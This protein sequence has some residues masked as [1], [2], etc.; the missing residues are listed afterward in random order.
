MQSFNIMV[1]HISGKANRTA[2]Y[3]SR[4]HIPPDQEHLLPLAHELMQSAQHAE[5][6]PEWG[7]TYD[8]RYSLP[9]T[10]MLN[11]L[12]AREGCLA[13]RPRPRRRGRRE[14]D[15]DDDDEHEHVSGN[16]NPAIPM[17][18][19][20]LPGE[21]AD[22]EH[23]DPDDPVEP[24]APALL[25]DEQML[26]NLH[27]ARQGHMGVA[28]TWAKLKDLYQSRSQLCCT[29]LIISDKLEYVLNG[30]EAPPNNG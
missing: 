27:N 17:K 20:V 12:N 23:S 10:A 1:R 4:L 29:E 21:P 11:C 14:E 7:V 22:G 6:E 15:D 13:A 30:A 18:V 19:P 8:P 26:D 2:D 24:E 5:T 25:S 9:Y 3:L 28:R 16:V